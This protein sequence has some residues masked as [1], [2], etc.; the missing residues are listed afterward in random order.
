MGLS[1]RGSNPGQSGRLLVGTWKQD[2]RSQALG[3]REP[4]GNWRQEKVRAD[5]GG[6]EG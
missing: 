4:R 5:P 1:N 2:A 3:W 6:A